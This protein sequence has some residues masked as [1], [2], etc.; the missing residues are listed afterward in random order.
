MT[1][2]RKTMNVAMLLHGYLPRT[3]D[4]YLGAVKDLSNHYNCSPDKL[5]MEQIQGWLLH[6]TK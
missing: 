3:S 6:L 4:R 2:L 5:S 1:P